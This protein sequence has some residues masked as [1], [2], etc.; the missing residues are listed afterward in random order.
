MHVFRLVGRVVLRHRYL[1]L[2][3]VGMLACFGFLM[4]SSVGSTSEGYEP[5]S[6]AVAVID[7]DDSELSRAIA[8]L[9]RDGG[10]E[11]ELPDTPYALQDAAAK[12]LASYVLV[13]PEG[14]GEA[15]VAAARDGAE[16]PVL[17]TVTSYRETS[18]ILMD[19]RVRAYAQQLFALL[20]ETGSSVEEAVA[21]AGEARQ[22]RTEVDLIQTEATGLPTGYLV[23]MQFST[24]AL[25]GSVGILVASGLRSLGRDQAARQRLLVAPLGTA[26][27]GAQVV[28]ACLAVAVFVWAALGALGILWC[29]GELAGVDGALVLLAQLPLLAL[30]IVGAAFGYLLWELG[31]SGDVIHAA[32]NISSMVLSF[33]GGTWVQQASM[34]AAVAAVGRLTPVWW[35]VSALG[36]VYAAPGPSEALLAEVAAS[37][38]LV[39]LF[40]LAIAAA[41]VAVGRARGRG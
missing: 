5:S 41:G 28:L 7:R 26:S 8:G 35:V 20:A 18:A 40:A 14:Y 1:I 25:F 16:M 17:E 27:W 12:D 9:V 10:E 36:C 21:W 31:S 29:R 13:I 22:A 15:L 3:Y 24:Y 37:C 23:F 38:G 4:A 30:S 11:V 33:L 34:G 2:L 19:E 6:P 39:L 32:G